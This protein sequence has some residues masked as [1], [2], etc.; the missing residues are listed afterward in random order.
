MF[1]LFRSRAS[2]AIFCKFNRIFLKDSLKD[3]MSTYLLIDSV[4]I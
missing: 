4:E 1:I 2:R 3:G